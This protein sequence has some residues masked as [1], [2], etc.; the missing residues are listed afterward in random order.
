MLIHFEHQRAAEF[1][2]TDLAGIVHFSN[3]FRW[4]EAAENAFLKS[5]GIATV[6]ATDTGFRGWPRVRAQAKFQ[7]PVYFG[8]PVKVQLTVSEIKP[9][10]VVYC[11]TIL[12]MRDGDSIKAATGSL[13]TVYVEKA[14]SDGTM[15]SI[16]IPEKLRNQLPEVSTQDISA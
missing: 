7:A 9:R 8:D 13:T 2:E 5:I 4:M 3:F 15:H 1:H 6:A 14:T 16:D 12:V 10:A 11:Y